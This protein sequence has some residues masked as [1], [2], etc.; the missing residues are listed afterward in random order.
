MQ[1]TA[2]VRKISKTFQYDLSF[3]FDLLSEWLFGFVSYSVF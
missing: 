3:I 1:I 2:E